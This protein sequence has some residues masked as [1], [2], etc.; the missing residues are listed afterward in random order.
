MQ[1]R[2]ESPEESGLCI[3]RKEGMLLVLDAVILPHDSQR[4]RA[5]CYHMPKSEK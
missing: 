3:I 4:T 1:R 5:S 2:V